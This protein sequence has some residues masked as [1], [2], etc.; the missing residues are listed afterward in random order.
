MRFEVKTDNRIYE[1]LSWPILFTILAY[2]CIIATNL[3]FNVS[4]LSKFYEINYF[5]K[6][7]IIDKS[8][9]NFKRLSKLTNLSNKQKVWDLC[10][11]LTTQKVF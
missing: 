9:Q 5:C 3:S 10:K 4:K 1:N 7:I 6:K 8:S 2:L 11:Q